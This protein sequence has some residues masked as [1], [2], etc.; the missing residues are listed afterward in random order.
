MLANV[1]TAHTEQTEAVAKHKP[2]EDP[3]YKPNV[4]PSGFFVPVGHGCGAVDDVA[5]AYPTP[6]LVQFVAPAAE[7]VSAGHAVQLAAPSL[8]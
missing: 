2:F 5:Q 4:P 1:P 3:T 8:L 6:Q 7:Y